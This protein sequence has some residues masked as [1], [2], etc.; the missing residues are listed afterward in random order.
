M[1]ELAT[2][3][4]VLNTIFQE[5]DKKMTGELR[6]DQLQMMHEDIRVGGLSMPQ[7]TSYFSSSL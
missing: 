3:Q 1:G 7:V 2:R 5:Y 6:A 4:D